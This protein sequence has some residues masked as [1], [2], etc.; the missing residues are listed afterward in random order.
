MQSL[1]SWSH[2]LASLALICVLLAISATPPA[3]AVTTP[4][5]YGPSGTLFAG[6]PAVLLP[7]QVTQVQKLGAT[8]VLVTYDPDVIELVSCTRSPAFNVGVC[9]PDVDR[10]G[11]GKADAVRFN[12]LSLDGVTTADT[13]VALVKITWQAVTGVITGTVTTLGVEV[14]TFA[15]VDGKPMAQAKVD[16]QVTVLPPSALK[17]TFL[18]L[19]TRR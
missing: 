15:D 4:L 6:R 10:N 13:P 11:D 3:A 19:V 7:V 16:G 12:A 9:N 5:V 8:T 14:E 2:I 18:P 1:R 17:M